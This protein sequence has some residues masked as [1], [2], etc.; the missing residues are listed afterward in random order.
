MK[1]FVWLGLL[2]FLLAGAAGARAAEVESLEVLRTE[3]EVTVRGSRQTAR[4]ASVRDWTVKG[5]NVSSL[6]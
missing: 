1:R 4:L 2:L 6:T 3:G 5:H